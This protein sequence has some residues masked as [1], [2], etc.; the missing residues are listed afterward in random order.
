MAVVR[1]L[2]TGEELKAH[3]VRADVSEFAW[4]LEL[5]RAGVVEL[6]APGTR[7]AILFAQAHERAR[8][9]EAGL[10]IEPLT[11]AAA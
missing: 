1:L 6:L 4:A 7:V 10:V 2:E 9:A 5:R 11:P 3:V 8:I